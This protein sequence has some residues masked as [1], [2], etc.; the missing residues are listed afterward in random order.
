MNMTAEDYWNAYLEKVAQDDLIG[1]VPHFYKV[2]EL[3]PAYGEYC[4]NHKDKAPVDKPDILEKEGKNYHTLELQPEQEKESY[5][6]ENVDF[7]W[8]RDN[9]K[10]K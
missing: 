5:L 2:M 8:W 7:I 1:S 3:E 10:G 9:V 6:I 4:R